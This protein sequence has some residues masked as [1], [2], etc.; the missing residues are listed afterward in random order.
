MKNRKLIII[1]SFI[2][3]LLLFSCLANNILS[4]NSYD[5]F[6]PFRPAKVGAEVKNLPFKLGEEINFNVVLNGIRIGTSKLT[7]LGVVENNKRQV[8]LVHLLTNAIN[9]K[10]LEKIFIDLDTFN[11]VWIVR[12]VDFFNKTEIITE[13]Y[14]F[15]PN[16]VKI[17]KFKN[18]KLISETVINS[19]MALQHVISSIYECRKRDDLV[20]GK[21]IL[22]NLP[23]KK[24]LLE[25]KGID[26]ISVPAGKFKA[27]H[28]ES[29]PRRYGF[30]LSADE[31]MIPLKI[32]GAISFLPATMVMRSYTDNVKTKE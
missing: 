7:Y 19:D 18:S 20:V 29:V 24:L 15:K 4:R 13:D 9:L 17:S 28:I 22:L 26:E 1:L 5:L 23:L 25:V 2:I 11:P 30:W 10:D 31:K 32:Q 14:T 6:K 21:K 12:N 3:A 16:S 8:L 27:I